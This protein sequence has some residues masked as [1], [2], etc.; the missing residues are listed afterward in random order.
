MAEDFPLV[1]PRKFMA[2][3]QG[4]TLRD[5]LKREFIIMIS[6]ITDEENIKVTTVDTKIKALI[7]GLFYDL[8][9]KFLLLRI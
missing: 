5:M 8:Y 1:R 4:I 2:E 7:S 6:M 9:L 3:V